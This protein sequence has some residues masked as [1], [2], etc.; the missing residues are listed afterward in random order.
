MRKT[1]LTILGSA[2]IVASS[3]QF[4]AAAER[5]HVRK[6]ERPAISVSEQVRNANASLARP[7][8]PG[9]YSDYSE[10]AMTSGLAGH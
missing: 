3:I 5:H 6:V 1:A 9:W 8:G 2:L 4:A 10:G 7:A